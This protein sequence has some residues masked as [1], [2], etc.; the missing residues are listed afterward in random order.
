MDSC[1]IAFVSL[2]LKSKLD[3]VVGDL[4]EGARKCSAPTAGLIDNP[5]L[6][7]G[8]HGQQRSVAPGHR[9]RDAARILKRRKANTI[10]GPKHLWPQKK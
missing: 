7:L 9:M 8:I 5:H 4:R 2:S 3:E 1:N 6:V 10:Q